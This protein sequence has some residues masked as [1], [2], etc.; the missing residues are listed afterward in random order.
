M[1]RPAKCFAR[2]AAT[3]SAEGLQNEIYEIGKRFPFENL[4]D[5]FKAVYEVVFGQTQG[6]RLGSF[7]ALYGTAETAALVREALAREVAA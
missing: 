4:R 3:C 7:V 2:V 6:P 5:W 1:R